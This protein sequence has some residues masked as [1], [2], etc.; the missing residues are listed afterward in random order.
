[1]ST[2]LKTLVSVL[3]VVSVTIG[4]IIGVR[5]LIPDPEP[6]RHSVLILV[7]TSR[8]M[9]KQFESGKT[10]FEA[11]RAQILDYAR[12]RPDSAIAVRFTGGICSTDYDEP[13]VSFDQDNTGEIEAALRD[14]SVGGPSDFAFAVGEAVNDFDHYEEGGS[15]TS[16]SIWA[17][18]GSGVDR[19]RNNAP[20]EIRRALE[21]FGDP[22]SVK[23]DFFA[24]GAS[25][26]EDR[27]L[28]RLVAG[29]NRAGYEA[30]VETPESVPEL[31]KSVENT[32][33]R[34]EPSV[35]D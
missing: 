14:V 32:S 20:R 10:K 25:Q 2:A 19:C 22:A 13:A 17:F 34:E 33:Q 31:K 28:T 8:S 18:L 24:V 4:I 27:K 1:V 35:S 5:T 30:Y 15:A 3:T 7:D 11:V 21:E 12:K 16:R 6:P 29:L 26:T 9:Q 23:F